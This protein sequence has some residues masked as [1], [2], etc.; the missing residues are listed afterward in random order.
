M[1]NNQLSVVDRNELRAAESIIEKGMATF[2]EVG[3]A[4]KVIC[5][6]KLYRETYDSFDKYVSQKW[7]L[8]K[9][10]AY[11][12]I[13]AC[14]VRQNLSTIVD[15]KDI[16]KNEAQ[17]REVSK[18]PEEK[19]A[20]VVQIANEVAKSENRNT[21]AS[22]YRNAVEIVTGAEKK[23]EPKPPEPEPDPLNP[24]SVAP[25]IIAIASRVDG[26]LREL[27]VIAQD[28]GGEWLP[29]DSIE[30]EAKQL[31]TSIRFAAFWAYCPTC[32]GTGAKGKCSTCK[33]FGW[34]ARSRKS[35][36]TAEVLAAIEG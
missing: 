36:V 21:T 3:S 12:L 15:E 5:D 6:K 31:K 7:G 9:S 24:E 8:E 35:L 17:L 13:N 18:A 10:R 22:D 14:E 16:P 27:K 23:P 29:M 28:I 19:Q 1:S 34:L 4:L 33:G 30:A 11:Q 26:M 32:E 2:I 25:Q 20:E